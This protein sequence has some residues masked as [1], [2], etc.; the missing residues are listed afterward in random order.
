MFDRH[1]AR[2]FLLSQVRLFSDTG[3]GRARRYLEL[4]YFHDQRRGEG[5]AG[6]S[7][8][9]A[10]APDCE[11][12]IEAALNE[13]EFASK[14][15]FGVFYGVLPRNQQRG[16]QASVT[17]CVTLFTDIDNY[18]LG[19]EA[20]EVI[21]ALEPTAPTWIISSGQGV[22][23]LWHLGYP[24]QREEWERMQEG[25]YRQLEVLGA[26]ARVRFDT[27]RVLRLPGFPHQ[28]DPAQPRQVRVIGGSE[29]RINL[30]NFKQAVPP[31]T[32]ERSAGLPAIPEEIGPDARA[33]GYEGRNDLLFRFGSLLR[34]KG[35]TEEVI[36][37]SL[38]AL[39]EHQ[40]NPPLDDAEV[41]SCV[42]SAM[43][44]ERGDLPVAD[45]EKRLTHTLGTLLEM[46]PEPAEE[47]FYGLTRGSVGLC[48]A[49]PST[50]KT[51][52]WLNVAISLACGRPFYQFV[53]EQ[54]PR[55]VFYFD[56]ENPKALLLPDVEKMI[57]VLTPEEQALV[58]RNLLIM[59]DE[60]IG[61]GA[62]MLSNE[63]HRAKVWEELEAF[64][65]DF[66]V[67][68]SVGYAF[69]VS[70]NDNSEVKERVMVPMGSWA[71]RLNAALVLLH[72]MG[73]GESGYLDPMQAGRG[74]SAFQELPR[75]IINLDP[76]ISPTG[77]SRHDQV[78]IT[79]T[80]NKLRPKF[81]PIT[82][83]INRD[84]RWYLPVGEQ[85]TQEAQLERHAKYTKVD[86]E[87]CTLLSDSLSQRHG[88]TNVEHLIVD[89]RTR[90]EILNKAQAEFILGEGLRRQMVTAVG[91]ATY[92]R[93][94]AL[95]I[96]ERERDRHAQL[97]AAGDGIETGAAGD[98]G[99]GTAGDAGWGAA[100]GAS[101]LSGGSEPDGGETLSP[102]AVECAESGASAVAGASGPAL[103]D[104]EPD[105]ESGAGTGGV[106]ITDADRIIERIDG[107][108]GDDTGHSRRLESL[109]T[110]IRRDDAGQS[111]D[112]PRATGRAFPAGNGVDRGCRGVTVST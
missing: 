52:F 80:K 81:E 11:K 59:V 83:E 32:P 92:V 23:A 89:A 46:V 33:E 62:V 66:I 67:V 18:K 74:A 73:K 24:E 16:D 42:E 53:K 57:Q 78:T 69:T 2:Q 37:A 109:L 65:P 60:E 96:W 20:S 86:H 103:G 105:A 51:S 48:Q 12:Q 112:S 13:A 97:V 95:T 25:I 6:S 36:R 100:A 29:A 58:K 22:Q 4:R 93:G 19:I 104:R 70:E 111:R 10:L 31:C 85:A 5:A 84:V 55:R 26:D 45:G 27:A 3:A 64:Q 79:N 47:L 21:A 43:R 61:G 7:W 39:N 8:I 102:A 41:E 90:G 68:D 75:M 44:Y 63:S 15:G 99:R 76:V 28:K 87:L 106:G 91:K 110:V 107:R 38:Q 98:P 101:R 17:D 72:H 49:K 9:D 71:K 77:M 1:T 35:C 14:R 30:A 56:A 82:F 54:E 40:C 108:G 50:G 94:I 88:A 34:G